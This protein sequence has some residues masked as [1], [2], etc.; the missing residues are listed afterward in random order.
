MILQSCPIMRGKFQQHKMQSYA[1]RKDFFLPSG[2]LSGSL[3][4]PRGEFRCLLISGRESPGREKASRRE[5][6]GSGCMRNGHPPGARGVPIMNSPTTR[7]VGLQCIEHCWSDTPL[8]VFREHASELHVRGGGNVGQCNSHSISGPFALICHT[9][10]TLYPK[11]PKS[12][13]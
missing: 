2:A 7:D 11:L 13:S 5:L 10:S 3:A 4:C 9:D 6:C 1:L 12:P 8:Y